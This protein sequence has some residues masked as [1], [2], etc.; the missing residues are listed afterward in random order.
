M[1]EQAMSTPN[2][3]Q[4]EVTISSAPPVLDNPNGRPTPQNNMEQAKPEEQDPV[5]QRSSNVNLEDLFEKAYTMAIS[6][7]TSFGQNIQTYQD[8]IFCIRTIEYPTYQVVCIDLNKYSVDNVLEKS[9]PVFYA[10]RTISTT[11]QNNKLKT[12]YYRDG[13]WTSYLVNT[14]YPKYQASRTGTHDDWDVDYESI[15]SKL[16]ENK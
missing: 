10:R 8:S 13:K 2:M 5:V 14:L 11:N 1:T 9:M 7:S 6:E 12:G 16:K 4:N 15:E 3:P